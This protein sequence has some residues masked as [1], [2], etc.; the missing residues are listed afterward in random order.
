MTLQIVAG[1]SRGAKIVKTCFQIVV[2]QRT[3]LTNC[4]LGEIE[5]AENELRR[6]SA[7]NL[8]KRNKLELENA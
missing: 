2:I 1:A 7:S 8:T 3:R 4:R 5:T 6:L